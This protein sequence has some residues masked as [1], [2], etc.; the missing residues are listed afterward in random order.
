MTK[1]ITK[2]VRGLP[3]TGDYELDKVFERLRALINEQLNIKER[4]IQYNLKVTGTNWT[5]T[6]AVGIPYRVFDEAKN[7]IWRLK[8]NIS[9]TLSTAA[10]SITITVD[11]KA[12][13]E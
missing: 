8:F 2:Q 6:R 9:G 1:L 3:S 11:R 4:E 10:A 7:E 13:P 12:I 5:T